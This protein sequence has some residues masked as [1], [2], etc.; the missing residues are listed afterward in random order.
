MLEVREWSGENS[1]L[2]DVLLRILNRHSHQAGAPFVASP[3]GFA[4]QR[5]GDV[6]G[7]VRGQ[8]I[9]DWLFVKYLAVAPEERGGGIGARLMTTIEAA[10]QRR[11]AVGAFVDTYAFQ[12]APF[13]ERLGYAEF[14][15]LPS[16]DLRTA[17]IYLVKPLSPSP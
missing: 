5:D 2:D 4:V 6:V 8:L 15:R 13:Y 14:G 16:A 7:G 12:A 3:L 11:G 10:A 17:R 1:E 9:F